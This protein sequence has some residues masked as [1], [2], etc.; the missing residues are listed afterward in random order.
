M[1]C[2]P[3]CPSTSS[4]AV[5]CASRSAD[6]A[7]M[8]CRT[9]RPGDLVQS[10]LERLHQGGRQLL[11]EP[12]GVGEGYLAPFR[13]LEL[14][15]GGIQRG[16]QLVVC[17]H[18]RLR[19]AV[20]QA[21]LAG[22]RVAG[23]G[24]L[25]HAAGIAPLALHGAHFGKMRQLALDGGDALAHHAAVHFQLA[26]AFAEARA[27]AAAHAVGRQM[28]PHA[29][30]ARQQVLVLGQPHLQAAFLAGGVQCEDVQ[31]E[32]R[33]VDD[34][35]VAP[36]GLLE[37]RLLRGSELVVEH[38]Q[39]GRVRA[40]E[41][42]HLLGLAGADEVLGFGASSLWEVTATTSAPAVSTRRSS[43]AS[44]EASGHA[45]PGRSTPTS[46]ARSRRSSETV[47][48]PRVMTDSNSD[49]GH[50]FPDATETVRNDE[51]R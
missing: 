11:D 17:Q 44:E 38:H 22:I 43:S 21:R 14:T 2:A 4:T 6:D 36:D 19:Q 15:R 49:I 1:S 41:F 29:A 7:S 31:D 40:D 30:Q 28:R 32:C 26:F 47:T 50:P 13:Q 33:A 27:D 8:T 24:N 18:V 34:L 46:T 3:I 39:V 20:E 35:H 16:E 48:A 5:I 37:V 23:Q 25:E 12:H 42:G 10:G 51:A 45:A 9:D